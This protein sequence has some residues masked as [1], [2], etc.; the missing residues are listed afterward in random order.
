[1]EKERASADIEKKTVDYFISHPYQKQKID[2]FVGPHTYALG[3]E[4]KSAIVRSRPMVQIFDKDAVLQAE[5]PLPIVRHQ[6]FPAKRSRKAYDE[7]TYPSVLT[8]EIYSNTPWAHS[9]IQKLAAEY[10]RLD[11][12]GLG[13]L[14]NYF[15]KSH[16]RLAIMEKGANVLSLVGNKIAGNMR[17]YNQDQ[18]DHGN[19]EIGFMSHQ[20]FRPGLHEHFSLTKCQELYQ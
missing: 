17:A 7:Y 1:M 4:G 2:G 16:H 9:A 18:E 3:K 8:N 13:D 20:E 14:Y 11:A 12:I 6:H 19:V 5:V 15:H 10:D